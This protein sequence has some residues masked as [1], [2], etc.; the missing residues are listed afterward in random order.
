MSNCNNIL[1]PLKLTPEEV[2]S[3]RKELGKNIDTPELVEKII[4]IVRAKKFRVD[5]NDLSEKL[6]S[7]A[8]NKLNDVLLNVKKPYKKLFNMLVG[9]KSGITSK[10]LARTHA[11]FGY[12]ASKLRMGNKDIKKLLKDSTP[13]QLI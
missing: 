1:S 3:L 2:T 6:T 7:D 13:T 4:D 8:M 5:S 9:E 12:F 10:A 11:R